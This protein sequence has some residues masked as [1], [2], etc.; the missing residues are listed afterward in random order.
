MPDRTTPQLTIIGEALIDVVHR[1]DATI[2][3][4]PGGS[5]ANVALT[6]GRLGHHPHL[7]TALGADHHGQQIRT[8]LETAGVTVTGAEIPST[9]TATAHLDPTGS[10]SYEFAINWRLNVAAANPADLIHTGSIA[11]IAD[12]AE[13]LTQL[14]DTRRT[15]ALITYDPNIRPSLVHDARG[16][17]TR[18]EALIRRADV[19]K[20]SEE[21]VAWLHPGES[22]A[23]VA[24]R[25][26]TCGP[27]MVVIT[28]GAEG[29]VAMAGGHELNITSPK[30]KAVDTVGAGDT[31]MGTLIDGLVAIG[32]AGPQGR[33]LLADQPA[34][35][36]QRLLQRSAQAASITVS[37]AGANPPDRTTLDAQRSSFLPH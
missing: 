12:G 21:D 35:V 8:W 20:A 2:T 1:A 28:R 25:W 11:A 16:T 4:T 24:R 13:E 18:V 36:L 9:A 15:E 23:S 31:F 33:A 29:A 37:R 6:L 14:I 10:A 26:A 17:R 27:K 30:V 34:D 7:L 19:V 22:I 5:P 3:E 32:A